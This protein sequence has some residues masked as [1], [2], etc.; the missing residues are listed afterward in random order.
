MIKTLK[1]ALAITPT[2]FAYAAQADCGKYQCDNVRV[3]AHYTDTN[4][5]AFVQLSGKPWQ[6]A[7]KKTRYVYVKVPRTAEDFTN[8][9]AHLATYK[10]MER[11][12]TV[13]IDPDAKEC[14]VEELRLPE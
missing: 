13:L 2:L 6:L 14:T 7:C 1:V 10:I 12:I 4:G 5:D 9:Y 3:V 11:P 8:I